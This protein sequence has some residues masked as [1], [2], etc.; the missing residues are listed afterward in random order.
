MSHELTKRILYHHRTQ[1][2]GVEGIHIRG[3]VDGFRRAGYEVDI[4]GPPGIDLYAQDIKKEKTKRPSR[5]YKLIS[6][7]APEFVFEFFEIIYNVYAYLNLNKFL[8]NREYDFVYERYAL[9]TFALSS[10]VYRHHLPYIIEVND[11]TII[12]RSRP[13]FLQRIARMIERKV[14]DQADIIIT[15]TN[16]F[17]NLIIE[18]YSIDREKIL[19][20]PNAIDPER[21]RIEPAKKLNKKQLN[22][23]ARYVIGCVGAFVPWH[24]LDFLIKSVH[25][26]LNEFDI[27][28]LFVGD[29]PVRCQIERLATR[30]GI[31]ER[32]TFTGFKPIKI[33]PY[34]IDL[35]DICVIPGSN[36][37]C[38]PMKLFEFMAMGKPIILPRYQPLLET[39]EDG[40]DGLF[41]DPQDGNQLCEA[42]RRLILDESERR[43]LG[44]ASRK[45]LFELYT[46]DHN[47]ETLLA[48]IG[49][50]K[51][52]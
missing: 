28:V 8:N 12:E 14:F 25:S 9:N 45:K 18:N 29:G 48:K 42:I 13:L 36:P 17:K 27:H 4:I 41:F 21:F 32:V 6:N 35:F 16:Y 15:I 33:I 44:S 49:S 22:I 47:V 26:L 43:R 10:L 23:N 1:G 38:S 11:A 34:Y 31:S 52:L 24:G 46:W 5:L 2:Q 20:L 7:F 40:R 51:F 3:M 19:V 39:L 37:H 30:Y 50:E